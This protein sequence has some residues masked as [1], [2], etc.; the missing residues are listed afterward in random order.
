MILETLKAPDLVPAI[1]VLPEITLLLS[2]ASSSPPA[3]FT[4]GVTRV[5]TL[6]AVAGLA[7][8][9]V[10]GV[11]GTVGADCGKGEADKSLLMQ[12]VATSGGGSAS[13]HSVYDDSC[14]LRV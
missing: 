5:A 8:I 4:D 14:I 13:A 11:M 7:V 10:F 6:E 2:S 3:C 12:A 9:I 1:V